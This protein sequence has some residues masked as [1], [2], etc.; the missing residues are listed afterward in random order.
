LH[1]DPGAAGNHS[2]VNRRTA[3]VIL[4]ETGADTGQFPSAA[5]LAPWA[6]LCPGNN[7][8][9]GKHHSARARKGSKWLRGA[10]EWAAHAAAPT[11]DTY[12]AAHHRRLHRT[13]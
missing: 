6:R 7:E 3:E 8:S 1:R 13:R 2:R 5:N 11:K 9:A 10:L 12:L 4:A